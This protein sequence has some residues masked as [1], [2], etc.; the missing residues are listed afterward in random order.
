VFY[1]HDVKVAARIHRFFGTPVGAVAVGIATFAWTWYMLGWGAAWRFAAI[2]IPLG[3]V[4]I[5]LGPL[6]GKSAFSSE[7]NER[8]H[9]SPARFALW[10]T[11]MV[12][13]LFL[14]GLHFTGM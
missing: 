6:F 2:I 1:N 4:D 3:A 7:V 9:D 8:Y 13:A 10:Y 11:G 5:S 14:L 12:V